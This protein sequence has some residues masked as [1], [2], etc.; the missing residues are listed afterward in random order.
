MQE[1]QEQDRRKFLKQAA[2]VAWATPLILTL[3]ASA[4]HGQVSAGPCGAP[5]GQQDSCNC[6]TGTQCASGCCCTGNGQPFG[7]CLQSGDCPPN[8]FSCL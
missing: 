6:T 3:G 8:F 7:F 4:A 2:T 5:T 1:G